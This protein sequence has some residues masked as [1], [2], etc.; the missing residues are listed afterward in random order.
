M[1]TFNIYGEFS[2]ENV[3]RNLNGKTFSGIF[4]GNFVDK[5]LWGIFLRNFYVAF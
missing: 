3:T 1:E 2:S 5:F 4:M